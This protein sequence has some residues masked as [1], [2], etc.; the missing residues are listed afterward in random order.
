MSANAHQPASDQAFPATAEELLRMA[1]S[2]GRVGL[3]ELELSQSDRISLSPELENLLEWRQGE[4]DGY[5]KSFLS[6]VYPADWRAMLKAFAKA[7][8]DRTD[9]E[10]EFRFRRGGRS[11]GWLLGRGRVYYNS[12]GEP[13][14]LAGVGIDITPQKTAALELLRLNA[15]LQQSVADQTAQLRAANDELDAFC[16]SVSHDLRAPLRSIRGFS[17][18]LL[19]RYSSKLDARGQE[20]LRRAGE[21]SQYM[22]ELVESLLKLSRVGRRDFAP[23]RVNLSSLAN[24]VAVELKAGDPSRQVEFQITPDLMAF[25]D[26]HLLRLALENLLG[27]AWKFTSRRPHAKIEFGRVDIAEKTFF[28]R[29]NGVGFDPAYASRLFGVFQR[30]HSPT[31]F[32]GVGVGLALVQRALNR[33]GGRVWAHAAVDRGATFYFILPENETR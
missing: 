3:W 24:L 30:L 27:N 21:S 1:L 6:R 31:E 11:E 19:E 7:V 12:R 17:E 26:E 22:D 13:T 8:R 2:A 9:P 32:P 20:F 18:V 25:G 15:K 28:V 10:L 29:D 4:F 14:R 16:Y 5:V 23:T 33:H